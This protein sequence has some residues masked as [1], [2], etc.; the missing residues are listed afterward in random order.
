MKRGW[1][2]IGLLFLGLGTARAEPAPNRFLERFGAF[3]PASVKRALREADGAGNPAA[4]DRVLRATITDGLTQGKISPNSA[5][6]LAHRIATP[7][8]R[9]DVALEL[10]QKLG[11]HLRF[12][13][14]RDLVLDTL[15]RGGGQARAMAVADEFSRQP[16][17][18][19][20][21]GGRFRRDKLRDFA[22]PPTPVPSSSSASRAS[23]VFNPM[24]PMSQFGPG[25]SFYRR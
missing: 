20:L 4:R 24:N 9:G 11:G 2:M 17:L 8:T 25:P 14:K 1:L 3:Q 7:E 6:Y 23:S 12:V 13:Q 21:A 15:Q 19:G 16:S 22:T 10:A 5:L 18:G